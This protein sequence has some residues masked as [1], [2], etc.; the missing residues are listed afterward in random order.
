MKK[1]LSIFL[2]V[3]MVLSMSTFALAE[4]NISVFVN[5]REVQFDVEPVIIEGRTMVPLRAI[6]EALGASVEWNNDTRSVT[7]VKEGTTVSLAI[8]SNVMTVNGMEKT[9][10]VPAQIVSDRTL[11]PVRAISEAFDCAVEWDNGSRSVLIYTSINVSVDIPSIPSYTNS[12]YTVINNNVPFFDIREFSPISFEYYSPLDWLSRADTALAVVGRDLMPQEARESI[13]SVKPTGWHSVTYDVISTKYLYNRCHLIGFQLSGE[14]ANEEN[15]ITG[16]AYMNVEGM[17]PFENM[18]ADYVKETDN[19][20]IY[21]V[22]P[23]FYG[24]ELVARG[25]LMEA[26]SI[27]DNGEGILFNVFCYNV[28]PGVYI[29]YADGQSSSDGTFS[30]VEEVTVTG[31]ILNT[32]SK[33]FHDADCGVGQR[34]SEANKETTNLSREELIAMGYSPCGTCKP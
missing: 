8:G 2:S 22:T 15:L 25:V 23:V 20:V 14:N 13:S 4:D 6:F 27:E 18:V 9:L 5:A 12:P 16:T 32:N 31:Y 7:S 30:Q 3:V 26:Y 1:F 29:N 10:D 19:H 28:Q 21:R 11:V 34:T 33:K 17:L 24:D